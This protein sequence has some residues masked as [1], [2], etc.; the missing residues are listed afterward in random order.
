MLQQRTL[1]TP[2]R[3][4]P[5]HTRCSEYPFPQT[6][7]DV[8]SIMTGWAPGDPSCA[9]ATWITRPC[10]TTKPEILRPRSL[11]APLERWR[12]L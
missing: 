3:D 2:L 8:L 1:E 7:Y 11:Y 12:S 6:I 9:Q 10:S 5:S 4:A